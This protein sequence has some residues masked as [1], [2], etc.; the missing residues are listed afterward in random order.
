MVRFPSFLALFVWLFAAVSAVHSQSVH[1]ETP[2]GPLPL[3]QT[4]ELQLVFENCAPNGEPAIPKVKGLSVQRM[5]GQS[6]NT[7]IINGHVTRQES[8]TYGVRATDRS[9]IVFPAFPIE[10]DKGK[11]NVPA[12]TFEVGDATVGQNAVALDSVANSRFIVPTEVWAGEVFPITYTANVARRYFYQ[13]GGQLEW[14]SSPIS[15]EEWAKPELFETAMNGE[16]RVVYS[17]KTRGYIKNPGPVMLNAGTQLMNLTTGSSNFGFFSRPTVEQYSIPSNRPALSVKPLPGNAPADFNGAVGQFKLESKVIPGA[18]GVGEP[19]TWTLTLSGTGNWPDVVGLPSRN[20]SKDFRVVQPQAK[21]TP[22]EGSLFDTTLTEDVVLIPTKAGTYSLGPITWSYF[23]PSKNAYQTATTPKVELVVSPNTPPPPPQTTVPDATKPAVSAQTGKDDLSHLTPPAAPPGAPGAIPR[24]PLP[25]SANALAPFS[26]R[27]LLLWSAIPVAG[28][29]LF[30]FSLAFRRARA[31]D[32]VRLQREARTRLIATIAQ[33]RGTKEPAKI[34]RL[35]RAWQHDT[36]ILWQFSRAVPTA[37]DFE[38]SPSLGESAGGTAVA[39]ASAPA[40]LT[41]TWKQLWSESDRALYGAQSAL[42]A[43]WA[44]RA[45]AALG[46][47]TVRSFSFLQLFRLENLIPLVI[48]TLAVFPALPLHAQDAKPAYDKGDFATA[49]KAWRE[50][51]THVPTDWI[52]H[53]NLSLALAQQDQWPEAA[54]HAATAFVQ[55]P[56]DPA[57]RWNF[58]FTSQHAG[59]TPSALGAFVHPTPLQLV[60]REF[61][62]GEWQALIVV[63]VFAVTFALALFLAKAYGAE[64]AFLRPAAWVLLIVGV[65][66]GAGSAFSLRLYSPANDIQAA[67]VWRT[68]TLRSVPTEADTTQKTTPLAA[69]T[70]ASINKTFLGWVQLAFNNGQTGWVRQDDLVKLWK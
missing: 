11:L 4:V 35:L 24:D 61:S 68:S 66:T 48:L 37:L 58:E 33:L 20:V 41:T 51:L 44:T 65:L 13:V 1:W 30:W 34:N 28:L 21:R 49:E 42:P 16:S 25:G 10:T 22:K 27:T 26:L 55:H 29:V 54:A 56:R 2:A 57:I 6:S 39:V 8:L 5:G 50:A 7:S 18:A 19:I 46:Q 23:D 15:T 70:I 60:A 9:K 53:H 40:V 62:P 3:N 14:N 64:S 52:A 63:A 59:Y 31:T 32:P 45:E 43:D 38:P 36:A 67:L 12:V 17:A 69:G 47:K